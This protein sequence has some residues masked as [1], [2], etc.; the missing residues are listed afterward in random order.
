MKNHSFYIPAPPV[1]VCVDSWTHGIPTG[2]LFSHNHRN[3]TP[4]LSLIQLLLQLQQTLEEQSAPQAPALSFLPPHRGVCATFSVQ[5]ILQ[6]NTTWQGCI[7]W[8]EQG[9]E[10]SFRSVLELL[11]LM[12]SAALNFSPAADRSPAV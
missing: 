10:A 2:R 8:L 6:E 7:A 11:S 3:G 4:F 9:T 1:L 12:D 5:V